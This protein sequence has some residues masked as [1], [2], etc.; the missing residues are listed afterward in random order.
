VVGATTASCGLRTIVPVGGCPF[1][2]TETYP[3]R[4]GTR[5]RS[6]DPA[7]DA[8]CHPPRLPSS[9]RLDPR[10]QGPFPHTAHQPP[11]LSRPGATSTDGSHLPHPLLALRVRLRGRHCCLGFAASAQLPITRSPALLQARSTRLA[12]YS[13]ERLGRVPSIDFCNCMNSQARPRMPK[14]RRCKCGGKHRAV[15]GVVLARRHQL[16]SYSP[17][18]ARPTK[19]TCEDRC[20]VRMSPP[21]LSPNLC[22]LRHPLSLT[23]IRRRMEQ[24]TVDDHTDPD[25]RRRRA[26]PLPTS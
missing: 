17:G 12:G 18:F 3:R 19:E 2:E 26:W 10:R 24:S 5:C 11:W 9:R 16:S 7:T 13:P 6:N 14:P 4:F 20:D 25:A 8:P 22:Y 23:S 21:R 1:A 15:G